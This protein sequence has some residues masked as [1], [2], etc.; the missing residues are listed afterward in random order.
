[1]K[2]KTASTTLTVKQVVKRGLLLLGLGLLLLQLWFFCQVC[3]FAW[4]NPSSTSMM[5][6]QLSQLQ[7]KQASIKLKHRW[8]PIKQISRHLQRAVI[9]AEDARFLQHHGFDWKG[10][11]LAYKKNI[12][13][14]K[15][16]AGGSTIS[17]QL[18]KNLFLSASKTPWRKGQEAIITLMIELILDKSRILE[19][20]LNV[21]EWGNGV[22][23]VQAASQ[24]YFGR[25]AK[26]LGRYQAAKLAV[27][28]PS[29]RY[30]DHH[31]NTA[32]LQTKMRRVLAS[33]H[34]AKLPSNT[35]K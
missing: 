12:K 8:V 20:Y 26:H 17:Q 24:H 15:L 10:I 22:F 7:K 5:D 21:V 34:T 2:K 19:L 23:G 14:G 18:A 28:L 25:S 33:M 29:P 27:M 1:M 4:F 3:W 31:R 35:V 32:F 9:T 6:Y 13:R 30:Y 11:K 16:V